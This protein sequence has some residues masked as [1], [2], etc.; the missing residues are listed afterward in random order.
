MDYVTDINLMKAREGDFMTSLMAFKLEQINTELTE[1]FNQLSDDQI[2]TA[3]ITGN[4]LHISTRPVPDILKDSLGL[5]LDNDGSFLEIEKAPPSE[6]VLPQLQAV[7]TFEKR[8][9]DLGTKLLEV[10]PDQNKNNRLFI[11]KIQ[12]A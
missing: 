5:F 11:A 7:K 12:M 2:I 6:T 8:C 1:T 4:D 9:E 10:K 3:S